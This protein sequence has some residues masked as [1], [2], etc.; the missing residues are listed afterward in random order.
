MQQLSEFIEK[1]KT[2]AVALIEKQKTDT[3]DLIEKQNVDAV[4]LIE[5]Q[6]ADAAALLVKQINA[7]R[8]KKAR[9]MCEIHE[10]LERIEKYKRDITSILGFS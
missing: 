6:K 10:Q 4:A 3:V 2:D 8:N 5:E 1:Q 9:E 7:S